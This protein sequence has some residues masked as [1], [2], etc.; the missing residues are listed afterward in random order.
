M[1]HQNYDYI[2]TLPPALLQ[3][4]LFAYTRATKAMIPGGRP[5][6]VDYLSD[7]DYSQPGETQKTKICKAIAGVMSFQNRSK[8]FS[9]DA[10]FYQLHNNNGVELPSLNEFIGFGYLNQVGEQMIASVRDAYLAYKNDLMSKGKEALWN[11]ARYIDIAT[12][13]YFFFIRFPS[14]TALNAEERLEVLSAALHKNFFS[15]ILDYAKARQCFD[16]S[17]I[18]MTAQEVLLYCKRIELTEEQVVSALMRGDVG[19]DT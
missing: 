5:D 1:F 19:D 7:Y 17:S 2:S 10:R 4:S 8:L 11:N 16:V 13:I 6:F 3:K 15:G 14:T 9:A 12:K 18:N